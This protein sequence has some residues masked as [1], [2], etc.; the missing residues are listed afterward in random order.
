MTVGAGNGS[1][2]STSTSTR[3]GAGTYNGAA[4]SSAPSSRFSSISN[5]TEVPPTYTV[6]NNGWVTVPKVRLTNILNFDM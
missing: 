2:V 4:S 1:V 5:N 6:H 3:T